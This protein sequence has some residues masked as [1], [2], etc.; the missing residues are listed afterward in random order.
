V[1][2]PKPI[3]SNTFPPN[4]ATGVPTNI[5]ALRIRF[6]RGIAAGTGAVI[7]HNSTDQTSQTITVPSS[8]IQTVGD[9][10]LITGVNLNF[11]KTYYVTFDSSAFDT[12]GFNAFGIYDS[13]QW[14]FSTVPPPPT[15]IN[16][17]FDSACANNAL[18]MGWSRINY[19]G[20]NQQWNCGGGVNPNKY[21]GING[22]TGGGGPFGGGSQDN[23]DWL[24]TPPI[25]LSGAT[26][27]M[28]YFNAFKRR[29]VGKNIEVYSSNNYLGTG[30]PYLANW[31]NLNVNFSMIDTGQWITFSAPLPTSNPLY[32]AF[33]YQCSS[34]FNDCAG[35]RVDSVI[36]TST[37]GILPVNEY[38]QMPVSVLGT[39]SNSNILIGFTAE[40]PSLYTAEVFDLTGRVLYK[41]ELNAL[42]GANRMNLY[43]PSLPS[44]LYIIRVSNGVTYGVTKAVVEE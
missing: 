36:V 11:G 6:D 43:T 32:I 35:W 38:N 42:T 34:S 5:P 22:Y 10:V 40:K 27:P 44:G 31:V 21:V 1:F 15:S 41:K 8:N 20:P 19:I 3:V 4:N 14:T 23:E 18:P 13:L 12:A 37:T 25:N 24:L 16:E 29:I 39:A 17:M 2:A 9:S 28:L 30:S 7:V 26:N 33:K